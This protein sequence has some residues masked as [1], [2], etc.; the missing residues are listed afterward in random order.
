[1]GNDKKKTMHTQSKNNRA[2][3]NYMDA[4]SILGKAVLFLVSRL[5]LKFVTVTYCEILFF[6]FTDASLTLG[7]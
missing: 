4:N 3:S 1:M 6:S 7:D 2:L 5:L